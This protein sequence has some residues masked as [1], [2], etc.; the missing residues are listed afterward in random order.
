METITISREELHR[1]VWETPT[2]HLCKQFGLSDVGLAK[3]CKRHDIPKPPPGYWAK[4]AHGWGG[5]KTP[6]PKCRDLRLETITF[7]GTTPVSEEA[8]KFC[9]PEI[10]ALYEQELSAEPITVRPFLRGAHPLITRFQNG[11]DDEWRLAIR[12]SPQLVRRALL[13]MDALLKGLEKRG[14]S[15]KKPES[16]WS[17]MTTIVGH[18]H[19]FGLRL[20][21]PTKRSV[22]DLTPSQIEYRKQYPSA[23]HRTRYDYIRSG[24]LRL[25]ITNCPSWQAKILRDGRKPL[26]ERLAGLPSEMLRAVDETRRQDAKR[27]E[28]ERLRKEAAQRRAEEQDR[29]K[30]RQERLQRRR[31]REVALFRVAKRWQRSSLLREFAA[32]VRAVA[33]EEVGAAETDSK[34]ARWL[35][36]AEKVADC[37]DP[38]V[39]LRRSS[40]G[41]RRPK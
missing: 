15:V 13:I 29:E 28:E 16:H 14:Y 34:I 6:L 37:H 40:P 9:D 5:R 7:C 8:S 23:Y 27:A 21:E 22:R 31:A 18:G 17:K 24:E 39:R 32:A 35:V 10:E 1:L 33:A 41:R 38:L 4:K 30:R 36:W 11:G 25:E 12:V 20:R 2:K 19:E 26:E 3:T